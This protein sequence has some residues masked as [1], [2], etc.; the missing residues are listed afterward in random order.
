MY[1][2]NMCMGTG[3]CPWGNPHMLGSVK[4]SIHVLDNSKNY[5]WLSLMIFKILFPIRNSDSAECLSSRAVEIFTFCDNQFYLTSIELILLLQ[6][7]FLFRTFS[8]LS[9]MHSSV[10]IK[11]FPMSLHGAECIAEGLLARPNTQILEFKILSFSSSV[12]T[13]QKSR[14]D[15]G[16]AY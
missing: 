6:W 8:H 9:L 14:G 2:A 3:V 15:E 13:S 16:L 12:K 11:P 5:K 7:L 4:K 1:R 10:L